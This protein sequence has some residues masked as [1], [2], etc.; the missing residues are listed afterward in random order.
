MA[1][2]W[3]PESLGLLAPSV[4]LELGVTAKAVID[5]KCPNKEPYI[6][7]IFLR[8]KTTTFRSKDI[9]K[10]CSWNDKKTIRSF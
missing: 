1:A 3:E 6:Y 8:S 2:G 4:G 9:K 7:K 5:P 10:I